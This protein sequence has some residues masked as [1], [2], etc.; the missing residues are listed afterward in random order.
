M[1]VTVTVATVRVW[2]TAGAVLVVVTAGTGN[3]AEQYD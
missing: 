2:M 1:V 3:L